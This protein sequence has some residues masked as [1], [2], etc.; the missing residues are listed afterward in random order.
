VSKDSEGSI[1]VVLRVEGTAEEGKSEKS[2]RN[3]HPDLK[4]N[5][6]RNLLKKALQ[7]GREGKVG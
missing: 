3:V 5:R 2:A 1:N 6:A 4:G 7:Q